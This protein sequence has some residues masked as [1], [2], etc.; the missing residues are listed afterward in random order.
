MQ[1]FYFVLIVSKEYCDLIDYNE[2]VKK[3]S[4]FTFSNSVMQIPIFLKLLN[5]NVIITYVNKKINTKKTVVHYY[6]VLGQIFNKI[7]S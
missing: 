1:T 6:M 5:S 7:N 4:S 2:L 3:Y